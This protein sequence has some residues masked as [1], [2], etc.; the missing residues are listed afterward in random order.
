MKVA[1]VSYKKGLILPTLKKFGHKIVSKN[2]ELVIAFGG[3]GTLLYAEEKY[4][5]KP[6]LFIYH[7]STCEKCSIHN[8]EPII[9]KLGKLK[10]ENLFK[11]EARVK[12]KRISALNDI[13]IHYSPPRALRFD[14]K[15]NGKTVAKNVIGDG[16][17]ISTPF[18]SK[19]YFYSITGRTFKKGI[20]IVFNNPTQ[21][22]RPIVAPESAKIEVKIL[23]ENGVVAHDTSKKLIGIK[24]GD[25]I[26]IQKCRK[27]TKVAMFKKRG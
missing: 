12:G 19:A 2:P 6:K 11:V 22:I 5:D 15:I 9:A 14:V 24:K 18:G 20:G 7:S 3:D 21:K 1:L 26:I 25:R 10:T 27:C 16:V 13:N 8:F 23:R 17:V 4:P